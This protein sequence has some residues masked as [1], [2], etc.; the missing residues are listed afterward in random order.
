MGLLLTESILP[1]LF[2]VSRETP[3]ELS[4]M[5]L[6]IRQQIIFNK[7]FLLKRAYCTISSHK[8]LIKQHC[9]TRCGLLD[10]III[11][12]HTANSGQFAD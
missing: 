8:K 4:L 3:D 10:S 11:T 6:I 5:L 1:A 7:Q 2:T 9:H 12:A